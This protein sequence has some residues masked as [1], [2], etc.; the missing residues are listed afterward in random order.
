MELRY[1]A[2]V[3]VR[4]VNSSDR[5][6]MAK[7]N[8]TTTTQILTA[9]R[10]GSP[11]ERAAQAAGVDRT[12]LWRWVKKGEADDGDG[13]RTRHAAF[14]RDFSKAEAEV[15]GR[16]EQHIVEASAGDWRAGAWWLQKRAPTSYGDTDPAER[17]EMQ[18]AMVT[19]LFDFLKDH[20][21]PATFEEVCTALG[22]WGDE[23]LDAKALPCPG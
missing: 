7:F 10:L 13:R 19:E 1:S 14:Y 6:N 21:S 16:V 20:L 23:G 8:E 12:T 4:D 9:M 5:C 15:I 17:I 2:T 22:T 18:K 3:R 11:L